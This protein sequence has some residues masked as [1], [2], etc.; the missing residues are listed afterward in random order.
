MSNSHISDNCRLDHCIIGENVA[1]GSNVIIGQGDN[2][3]NEHKPGIYNSGITVVGEGADIPDE[4]VIGRNVMIDIHARRED[5]CSREIPSGSSI[6][7]GGV[8]E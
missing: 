7:N 5:F 1:V 2:I 6:Y 3:P 4:S 8:C